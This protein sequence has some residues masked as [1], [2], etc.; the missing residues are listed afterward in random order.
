MMNKHKTNWHLILYPTLWAYRN[1]KASI[2]FTHFHLIFEE[3]VVLPIEYEIPSLHLAIALL[4]DSQPL[5]KWLIMLEHSTEY[6]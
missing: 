5:E 1:V 4:L 6:H 3:E 2:G